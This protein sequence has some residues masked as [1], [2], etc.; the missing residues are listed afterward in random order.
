MTKSQIQSRELYAKARPF[1]KWVGGKRSILPQLLK[2][3]PRSYGRYYEPFVGGGAL[4]FALQP[5]KASLADANARLITTYQALKSDV[6]SVIQYIKKHQ[7][8]HCSE[9]YLASRNRLSHEHDPIEVAALFIY[10]N[11]TCFNGLYRVNRAGKFN[12]PIGRQKNTSIFN[13]DN[14]YRVAQCLQNTNLHIRHFCATPVYSRAFYYLDP[15]YHQTYDAYTACGFGD[16]AHEQLAA[17]CHKIHQKG[18]YFM[19]SNAY[20]PFVRKLYR[21]YRIERISALKSISCKGYQRGK[22]HECIIRNY[23]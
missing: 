13:E 12:V 6:A 19:L 9:Y 16:E 7:K 10:L 2:R 8:Q 3:M 20:T 15:P 21:P 23:E 5:K 14:L 4:F 18:G 17:Y 11:K 22:N 1:V